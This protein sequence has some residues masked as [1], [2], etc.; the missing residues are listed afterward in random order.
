MRVLVVII[1]L[2]DAAFG[3]PF[4]LTNTQGAVLSGSFRVGPPGATVVHTSSNGIILGLE[5]ARTS[6]VAGERLTGT[7]IVSNGGTVL[8]VFPSIRGWG[9][10]DTGIGNFGV[11]DE[12]GNILPRTVPRYYTRAMMGSKGNY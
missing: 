7:M 9:G 11:T 3:A 12:T 1:M 5:F 2:S 4:A 8:A 6:I 10:A